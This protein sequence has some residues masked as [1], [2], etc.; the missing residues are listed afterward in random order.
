MRWQ[1]REGPDEFV[2]ALG[3]SSFA[4][5]EHEDAESRVL[6]ADDG[7][8]ALGR[9]ARDPRHMHMLRDVYLTL[10]DGGR[11]RSLSDFVVVAGLIEALHMARLVVRVLPVRILRTD[12]RGAPGD[13]D[14]I[15][16]LRDLA[17]L[18]S[19]EPEP[20]PEPPPSEAVLHQIEILQ[21]AAAQGTPFCEECECD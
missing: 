12:V 10:V 5:A 7:T 14:V 17:S 1:L 9:L 18:S 11:G 20:V 4:A 8:D 19:P 3:R 2:L 15:T 16:D 21:R 6:D 13:A